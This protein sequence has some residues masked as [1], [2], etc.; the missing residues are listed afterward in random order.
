MA[1]VAAHADRVDETRL[2]LLEQEVA[3][4]V[5]AAESLRATTQALGAERNSFAAENVLPRIGRTQAALAAGHLTSALTE[6]ADVTRAFGGQP[7]YGTVNDF[8]AWMTD[9]AAT[10]TLDPNW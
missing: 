2:A 6:L 4:A 7:I 5:L 9:R 8:D 1:L 10:L 3:T